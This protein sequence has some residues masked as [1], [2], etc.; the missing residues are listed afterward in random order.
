MFITA[1]VRMMTMGIKR[2]KLNR[3]I[4]IKHVPI[5]MCVHV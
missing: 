5:A 3:K 1:E 2:K 4:L